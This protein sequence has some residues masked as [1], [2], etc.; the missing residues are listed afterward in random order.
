MHYLLVRHSQLEQGHALC[1]SPM[2]HCHGSSIF[3][4]CA[5]S[6][7]QL[8]HK[9]S[10][11]QR[12]HNCIELLSAWSPWAQELLRHWDSL[13]AQ[14][15]NIKGWSL[16]SYTMPLIRSFTGLVMSTWQTAAEGAILVT[17]WGF[18]VANLVTSHLNICWLNSVNKDKW[19]I[20]AFTEEKHLSKQM[21][22][23]A[24]ISQS[25]KQRNRDTWRNTRQNLLTR[26][27]HH[28]FSISAWGL[29]TK[30]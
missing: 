17:E 28:W 25:V 14:H 24:H 6:K 5:L 20:W 21:T 7:L 9:G 10:I 13:S 29:P 8:M 18:S 12:T 30:I 3:Q 11:S 15:V 1:P 23:L 26:F 16:D 2:L 4:H 27:H 22:H 19:V